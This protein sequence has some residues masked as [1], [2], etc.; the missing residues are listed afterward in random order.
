MVVM[1]PDHAPG[2]GIQRS[3]AKNAANSNAS[4]RGHKSEGKQ[5][6]GVDVTFS[7]SLIR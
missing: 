3:I 5:E 6:P 1:G 2:S 4:N 7:H